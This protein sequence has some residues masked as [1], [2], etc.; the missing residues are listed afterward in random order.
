MN[1]RIPELLECGEEIVITDE[2]RK[3]FDPEEIKELTMSKIYKNEKRTKHTKR[4]SMILI[5]AAL[6]MALT[7]SAFAAYRYIA[8][9]FDDYFGGVTEQQAVVLE[10]IGAG[11]IQA[12]TANGTTLTPLAVIGDDYRSY[13]KFRVEA[14]EGT[15]LPVIDD[16]SVFPQIFGDEEDEWYSIVDE[17][18]GELSVY[19]NEMTW[20]DT[21]PGDN[22]LEF[23]ACFSSD[24]NH[25]VHFND[26][27]SKILTIKGIWLQDPGKGYTKLL[28]GPWSF[29]IGFYSGIG[30]KTLDVDG[31]SVKS[32]EDGVEI[33]DNGRSIT[34]RSMSISPLTLTYGYDYT[35]SDPNV[36]PG[37][38][39]VQI[40]M[41]DGSI[42]EVIGGQG[43]DTGSYCEEDCIIQ[44]PI[45]LDE[46]DYIQFGD[47][48]IRIS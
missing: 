45:D 39:T 20:T 10:Q 8:D 41:K 28:D 9:Q 46:V 26:G 23:V 27:K 38:G 48:Q 30:A 11:E 18:G 19:I 17:N 32:M 4:F 37:P 5:A 1:K 15:Q 22:V 2:V 44:T 6:T 7:A 13:L 12:S 31:L 21:E 14:P 47:Q 43:S 3:M 33:E 36:I 16:G 40:V 25:P 42:A 35:I 29:D 24:V 34:L